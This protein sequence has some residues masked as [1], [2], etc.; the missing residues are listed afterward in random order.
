MHMRIAMLGFGNVGRALAGLLLRKA[1]VLRDDYGLTY[2]VTGIATQTRGRAINADGLDLTAAL[3]LVERGA[4]L[5]ALHAGP[6]V[7]DTL[8]FIVACPADL[9]MEATWLNPHT[10]QPATDYARAALGKGRHLVTAN[11]GPV[12]FAYREL[13][14]LADARGVGFFFESTVMDG[15]PVHAIGREA[16]LATTIQR[17]RGVL[18]STTNFILTRLEE[19]VPFEQAVAQAQA[20]GVAEADPSTDLEGWDAAVKIV[21]LANVLMGADLRPA[22]VARR[23]ITGITVAEAQAAVM[24]GERI[25]LLCEAVR[26]GDSVRASVRP[27]RLS[28]SDPLSQ[29]SRTSSAVTF[30]TDTLHEL[31]LVEGDTDPTTTAYGMLVDM[32]NIARGRHHAG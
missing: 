23:G 2:T 19:G 6:P 26:D 22:E 1:D 13:K 32:I 10:G 24:A 25:K 30:Q 14:T 28:L 7:T 18:N 15:A 4:A 27:V 5:D 9:F 20:I 16:L 8:A 17:V 29:V 3:A 12:A 11:K 31:T 21:V